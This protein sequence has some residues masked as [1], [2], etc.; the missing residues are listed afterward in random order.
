MRRFN[1]LSVAVKIMSAVILASLVA[2]VAGALGVL[3]ARDL[4]QHSESIYSQG[5]KPVVALDRAYVAQDDDRRELLNVL[6]SVDA[7]ERADNAADVKAADEAFAAAIEE[8]RPFTDGSGHE[9]ELAAVE[10]AW[11]QYST[12]RDTVLM[13]LALAGD[14]AGFAAERDAAAESSE[15]VESTLTA[16]AAF[17]DADAAELNALAQDKV[18]DV[19]VRTVAVA[20]IGLALSLG[21]GLVV[22][23]GIVRPLRKVSDVLAGLADGDLTGRVELERADEVGV[24]ATSLDS[25]LEALS[26]TIGAVDASTSTVAAAAEELSTTSDAIASG[27]ESS[28]LQA[29]TVSAAAD[30]VSASIASV[31]TAT[32]ELT[33][34]MGEI[35]SSAASAAAV[36]SAAVEKADG[37]RT[38]VA[39]LE[40]ASMAI[41]ESVKLLKA[42]ADQ[43]RMLALNA[44]IE[45]AR[46]GEAGKGFAVVASEVKDLAATSAA[47]ADSIEKVVAAVQASTYDAVRSI[48]EIGDVID[49]VNGH[50]A[51]I[52]SAV[53]EQSA[54]A[55][56]MSRLVNDAARGAQE[57]AVNVSA[58][59]ASQEGAAA[60]AEQSRTAS[61]ELTG[62]SSDLASAVHHFKI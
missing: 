15:A 4:G 10:S 17:E 14:V 5:L 56:E 46:A 42:V 37:A 22:S 20:F 30:Q 16:L 61:A 38:T 49:E 26:A 31:S 34:S 25:A 60:S 58:V 6:I 48:T 18:Q 62:L 1:D 59:A 9:D 35:A 33:A 47:A 23:R 7:A 54:V 11:A 19:L 39:G 57:I 27:A 12:V 21:L 55:A 51:T 36:A 50:Q 53:E 43:T 29:T 40:N 13:P 41:N 52:A 8:Y 44:T 32:E 24:M 2:L 3:N 28:L 45:A